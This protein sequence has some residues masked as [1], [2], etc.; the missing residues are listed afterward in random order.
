ML[1][2]SKDKSPLV[3]NMGPVNLGQV[4][5]RRFDSKETLSDSYMKFEDYDNL[6]VLSVG[7]VSSTEYWH[8]FSTVRAPQNDTQKKG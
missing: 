8:E 6:S 4:F 2:M 3:P 7:S 5:K 1:I